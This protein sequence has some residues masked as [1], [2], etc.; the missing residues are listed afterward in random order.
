MLE[1]KFF[2]LSLTTWIVLVLI[3][4]YFF[5]CRKEQELFTDEADNKLKIYNFN[6]SWC[7]YSKDFQPIWDNFQKKY[8][9]NS[10]VEIMDVKCDDDSNE[11]AQGLCKQYDIPG[12]PSIIF[13]KGNKIVDYQG[14]RTVEGLAEQM[15]TLL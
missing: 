9:N 4:V 15:K 6:T 12:Y 14:K 2:G 7:G 10:N 3:S 11:N 8:K 1:H 13:H 5:W